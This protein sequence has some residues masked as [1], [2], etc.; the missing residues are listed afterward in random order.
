MPNL[1][2]FDEGRLMGAIW[3]STI[4]L[5]TTTSEMVGYK[6]GLALSKRDLGRF[7]PDYL[8]DA[9]RGHDQQMVRVRS[10]EFEELVA[11]CLHGV[12]NI[13][14]PSIV[15]PGIRQFHKYKDDPAAFETLKEIMGRLP[16]FLTRGMAE[17]QALGRKAMDP[18]PFL[19]ESRA[20]HG[21]LGAQI[22][23]EAL[24]D[25]NL[26]L[27]VSPW[28]PYRRVQWTDAVQLE[29]LFHSESLET[30]YGTFID[31]R[32][33][34]YLAANFDDVDKMNWRKFEG[35]TGEYFDREGFYVELGPG[36]NDGNIDA[37]VWP[38]KEDKEFPPAILVQ[39]KRERRR[40][41]K[42][43]VK[44]L[45]ADIVDEKAHSGL[46]VTTSSLSPGAAAV[47]TARSYPIEEANRST[48]RA[49]VEKMRTPRSGVFLGE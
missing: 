26:H 15:P 22:A 42:V 23:V 30:Q 34:D 11:H 31:Q 19:D 21:L 7:V 3:F 12:G 37:R 43:V 35:L 20:R 44:A 48:L 29:E 5:V 41:G 38:K 17:A 32:F 24:A 39:C 27:H 28:G 45:W 47:R 13:P 8:R 4:E 6:S 2:P 10:E 16:A 1:P 36:R 14:A 40:V 33:V 9:W 46:I 49:W 25:L 18:R